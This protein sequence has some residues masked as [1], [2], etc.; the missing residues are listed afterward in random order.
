M[1]IF[2]LLFITV[3]DVDVHKLLLLLFHQLIIRTKLELAI[4]PSMQSIRSKLLI[5]RTLSK[6]TKL[7]LAICP[8]MQS[9]RS[10]LLIFRTK[11]TERDRKLVH[12]F[13]KKNNL[14]QLIHFIEH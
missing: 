7:E 11:K 9:I 10:K 5:F 12:F 6:K 13:I 1:S 2:I 8:S 14:C 3:I 4:C